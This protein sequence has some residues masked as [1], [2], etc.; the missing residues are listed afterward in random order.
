VTAPQFLPWLEKYMDQRMVPPTPKDAKKYDESEPRDERGRWTSGGASDWTSAPESRLLHA[1]P[2]NGYTAER[3]AMHKQMIGALLANGVPVEHPTVT[4]LGGGP[5][6]GKSTIVS[7]GFL[8][9]PSGT[10]LI[11]PDAIKTQIPEYKFMRDEGGK[12]SQYASSYVHEEGSYVSKEAM[13]EALA[14]RF[15]LLYDTTGDN[16]YSNLASK[17]ESWRANG[18]DR[19]DAVY[20]TCDTDEAWRRAQDRYDSGGRYVPET[21]LRDTHSSVTR[22]VEQGINDR[23]WDNFSL[24]DTNVGTPKLV[25]SYADKGDLTIHDPTA[26]DAFVAKGTV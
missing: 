26:W 23:L 4:M 16:S 15:N 10:V 14:D 12:A 5:A 7:S 18:A 19:I 13:R 2:V 17:V 8:N 11:D 22:V 25:A 20:A 6:A 1:G 9:V 21:Y 3:D 24:Y